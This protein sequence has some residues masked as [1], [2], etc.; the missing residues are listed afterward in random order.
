MYNLSTK[1]NYLGEQRCHYDCNSCVCFSKKSG[2]RDLSFLFSTFLYS[3]NSSKFNLQTPKA[4]IK[5][6][7]NNMEF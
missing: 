3:L 6:H 2:T 7:L 4:E 5:K 1:F